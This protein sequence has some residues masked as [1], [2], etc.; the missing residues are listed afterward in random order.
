MVLVELVRVVH[1]LGL[2]GL[3]WVLVDKHALVDVGNTTGWLHVVDVEL[4]VLFVGGWVVEV[5]LVVARLLLLLLLLGQMVVMVMVGVV[6]IRYHVGRL[7][8][9]PLVVRRLEE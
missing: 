1:G 9:I 2:M 4:W 3:W 7:E 8:L 6:W 5:W